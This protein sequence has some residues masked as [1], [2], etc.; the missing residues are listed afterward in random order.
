MIDVTLLGTG[1]SIPLPHRFLSAGIIEYNGRKILID[2]GEGTQVSMRAINSGFRN[3]DVIC[4][5]HLHGDH[6]IGLQGMLGTTSNTGRTEP[7]TIIGPKG[8][9]DVLAGFRLISPF[10]NYDINLIED[11]Q[12]PITITNEHINGEI[13]IDTLPVQH[14]RPCLAYRINLARKPKF[15]IEKARKN[16]V[17]QRIWST[18]QKDT[19]AR[20]ELDGKTYTSDMVLG[21]ARGGLSVSWVTDTLPISQIVPFVQHSDLL[22]SCANY[23]SDDDMQKAEKNCHMTFS[24]AATL[25]KKAEVKELVLTHFSQAMRT[26]QDFAQNATDIFPQTIIG[27]DH[28]HFELNYDQAFAEPDIIASN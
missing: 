18:L 5:T 16:E 23:G 9:G 7:I 17:P 28:M 24:Q 15:D 10:L 6:V 27:Q 1:G 8:L 14:T 13:T 2:C 12:G 19:G 4:I 21:D 3:I 11:P 26:P 25:A 20:V 22:V